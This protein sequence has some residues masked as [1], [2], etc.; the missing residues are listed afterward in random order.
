[1]KPQTYT[2]YDPISNYP[3]KIVSPFPLKNKYWAI[4]PAYAE[5][6][7]DVYKHTKSI[8]LRNESLY[9]IQTK[10]LAFGVLLFKLS[11][12][13]ILEFRQFKSL[14]LSYNF[15]ADHDLI[16]KFFYVVTKIT[17][18]SARE[19]KRLPGFRITDN[20]LG[21]IGPWLDH[22]IR[23]FNKVDEVKRNSN[24]DDEFTKL[25]L[26]YQKWKLY[27]TAPDK[28][29]SK[30]IHYVNT[31]TAMTPEKIAKWRI[32]FQESAGTLYLKHRIKSTE[33]I[34]LFW[35]LLE[36][37][38]HIECADYQN[39]LTK[40]VTK[41]LKRKIQSWVD[42]HPQF[43]ELSLDYRL[44][45]PKKTAIEGLDAFW[46]DYDK[47]ESVERE[48]RKVLADSVAKRIAERK[49]LRD[50]EQSKAVHSF[51]IILPVPKGD[52]L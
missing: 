13:T 22:C 1:M 24:Y 12:T 42:W 34:D 28:L 14:D 21:A 37:T 17:H 31:V 25:N 8:L 49:A 23:A 38:D 29:P 10:R 41:F 4:H 27:S 39:S 36:C 18:A 5:E 11:E 30:V 46:V 2:V 48:E 26:V 47:E 3:F 20:Q 7:A 9:N 50:K 40:S 15:F 6:F 35:E 16:A 51:D 44:L 45:T 43:L 33:S 52:T 32:F 19:R